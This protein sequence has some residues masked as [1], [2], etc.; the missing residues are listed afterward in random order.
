MKYHYAIVI[1]KG[2]TS[3]GAY[4]PDLPGCVAVGDTLKEVQR[5]IAEAIEFHIEGMLLD[6][7]PEPAKPTSLCYQVDIDIA[8]IRKVVRQQTRIA[9]GCPNGR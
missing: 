6:G 7:D 1:E 3:Y 4:V 2:E 8:K 9:Q 5:L